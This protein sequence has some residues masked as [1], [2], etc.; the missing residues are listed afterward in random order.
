LGDAWTVATVVHGVEHVVDGA[1]VGMFEP[2]LRGP[3]QVQAEQRA[4]LGLD[5]E[6]GVAAM[7]TR[8]RAAVIGRRHST[9]GRRARRKTSISDIT[10]PAPGR[11]YSGGRDRCYDTGF[12][13]TTR[14][15]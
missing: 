14:N 5:N 6:D 11:A 15:R 12:R 4:G 9:H 7:R 2:D 13:I 10:H 3:S 1:R 8:S